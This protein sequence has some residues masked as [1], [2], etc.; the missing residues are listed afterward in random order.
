MTTNKTLDRIFEFKQRLKTVN[1][2]LGALS[3]DMCEFVAETA[4]TEVGLP[5]AVT[6]VGG[7]V[8]SAMR[9]IELAVL[10]IDRTKTLIK[11]PE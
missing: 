2:E 7:A 5:M 10:S 9:V 1:R 8:M 4:E 11:E 6:L 3:D